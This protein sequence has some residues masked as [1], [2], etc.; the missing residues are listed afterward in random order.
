MTPPVIRSARPGDRAELLRMRLLLWPDSK[1]EEVVALLASPEAL[2]ASPESYAVFVAEQ[3][4][5][6]LCGFAEVGLR[7][8]AEG[9]T[10]SPVGYLEGIWVDPSARRSSVGRALVRAAEAWAVDRGCT[11]FASDC[12]ID[13]DASAAFHRALGFEEVERII[14]FRRSL[15]AGP[16]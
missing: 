15:G 16:V 2:L 10:T 12:L 11:E 8:Y 1:G 13:N 14:C 4:P 7:G 6:G 3:E 5:R 9:C